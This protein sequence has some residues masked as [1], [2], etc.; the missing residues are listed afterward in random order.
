M[1]T[2]T[3]QIVGTRERL[4]MAEESSYGSAADLSTD[5]FTLGRNPTWEPDDNEGYQLIAAAGEDDVQ[6][7]KEPGPRRRAGT[8]EFSPQDWRWLKFVTGNGSSDVSD[9]DQ[10]SY[11]SHQ[12]SNNSAVASFTFE[13][14]LQHSSNGYGV[15]YT[16]CQVN[17]ATLSF[18]AAQ[19]E[20]GGNA[21]VNAALEVVAQDGTKI[22]TLNAG[23]PP[24]T[25]AFKFHN[26]T[27]TLA[28]TE[29][30]EVM[31][32]SIVINNNLNEAR[33]A[34]FDTLDTVKD[35][36]TPQLRR[37]NGSIRVHYTDSTFFDHLA[38]RTTLSGTNRV[39][40]KRGTNDLLQLD[41]TNFRVE[42]LSDPT[43]TEG[44]NEAQIGFSAD[45]VVPYA[46]DQISSY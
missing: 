39:E 14:F 9:T 36:S 1:T 44:T 37:V 26:Q 32:G 18:Q 35:R 12:F 40:L 24:S 11:H 46:E 20:E 21:L 7:T 16:G 25:D 2:I 10:G 42:D 30:V 5:G 29:T 45:A 15:Q 31:A 27:L 3:E 4:A 34:N 28:G 38:G 19:G 22:T 23:S 8:L 41:F 6:P 17:Q 13:R 43:N 33:Y